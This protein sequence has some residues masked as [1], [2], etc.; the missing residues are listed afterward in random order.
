MRPRSARQ[1]RALR[2]VSFVFVALLA[3]LAA[4]PGCTRVGNLQHP[5]QRNSWTMPGV[6][7]MAG[8]QDPDTLDVLLGTQTVD[9]DLSMFW[10]GYLFNWSDRNRLE[11]ELAVREPTVANGDI[12]RDG[13]TIVYR[14]RRGVL[15]QDGAPF[16]A[17]DVIYTWHQML[18]P[19]NAV[20]TRIGYD[21]VSNIERRG[22]YTIA[23]HLKHRFAPF[24]AS[25]FT[26]AN[27][28][29]CILPK[30]LLAQYPDIN[31][32]AYNDLPVG[33][34][35]FRIARYERG[36]AIEF[37]ANERY[38]RGPP[39]LARI[40]YRII[41][42]DNTMLAMLQSHQ[43]DFFFRAP[44]TMAE[45]LRNV[46][47]TRVVLSPFTRYA[48][49]GFNAAVPALGDVRMRQA[50]A[51]ATDRRSLIDKVTHGI[52]IAGDT[53]QPPFFWAYDPHARHYA[54]DLG[55][56]QR[57][58]DA[59]GWRRTQPGGIRERRGVPLALTLVSFTGSGTAA[60]AEALIQAQWRQAGVD[61]TIKNYPSGQLY[62]T[63]SMGGIEQS[64]KFDV[65]FENWANG[66]DPDDSILILCSMAPP[67][68]WNVYHFCSPALDAAERTALASYDPAV[69]RAAYARIQEIAAEGLP[70]LVL[71]YQRELDV[72]N[73]D[74]KNYRPAHA[75]TPFWN[76]W[77]WSI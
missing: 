63:K 31:H 20:T 49:I 7:R 27:H 39:K 57:M 32:V 58:L 35:P 68:G 41:P 21:V 23:V 66:T 36:T 62:A 72:V 10:A 64:G 1:A 65:I 8:R 15:W 42:S 11:P 70:F 75:V 12:S 45:S 44:E 18:N 53:D 6:L 26:M 67:A 17:D 51:Y 4:G 71:W 38:W 54:Y 29:D 5:G 33:T 28:P 16:G 74:L 69:R 50:L 30:H 14:L 37:V 22:P 59:A 56:A 13:L 55:L 47:G 77:Q 40:D 25:F 52:T 9:T 19:R 60:A 43:L 48:D 46:P 24:V 76:A 34:G 61:V 73:T 2:P 3:S